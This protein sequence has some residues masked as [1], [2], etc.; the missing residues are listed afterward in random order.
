MAVTR[1]RFESGMTYE[2]YK[3]QMTRNQDRFLDNEQAVTLR[4]E[5]V[6]FFKN[7]P[8][9]LHALILAE[10]WCGDVINNVPVVGQLAAQSGKLDIRVLLRDQNLDIMDRYLNHGAYRSV[11]TFIIMD[12]QLRELG[13]LKE[14]P[15]P[16]TRTLEAE[17]L[18]VRRGLREQ[19]K[20][21]WRA[22]TIAALRATVG[23]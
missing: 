21:P 17:Q 11:P 14:R 15:E 23:G 19:N 10:D 9:P 7:L 12:D 3:A 8:Q 1:E 16:I 18:A 20:L 6:E 5:D 4:P 22:T 13:N 2:A